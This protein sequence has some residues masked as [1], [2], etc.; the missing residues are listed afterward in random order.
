MPP[1]FGDHEQK[2]NDSTSLEMRED[3]EKRIGRNPHPDFAKVQASRPDWR[4]EESWHFTKTANPDW[5]FGHG[6][7]DSGKSL[8]KRHVE[9]DPYEDGR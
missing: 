8:E 2:P 1:N 7:S 9:I 3:S 4:Q 5:K 6:A